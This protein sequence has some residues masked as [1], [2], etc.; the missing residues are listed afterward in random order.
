[1]KRWLNLAVAA[2]GLV[3]AAAATARAE[4]VPALAAISDT[5]ERAR[6]QAL[7]EGARKEG[8]LSWIGVQIEPGHANPILAEF[9]RYYGLDDLKGEYTYAGTGEI[10][11][12][13][14]QLLRAKRKEFDIVW[15]ASWAWYKDLLK[16]G[17]IMQYDSPHYAAYTLSDQNGMSQKGYWA[18]DAY[19]FA[20]IYNPQTMEQNGLKNFNPTSWNDFVDP[21][22]AGRICM[23]DVMVS[24]SAAPVLAGVVKAMGDEWLKKLGALKPALHIKAAQGR[25][26]VGSGEFAAT[27]L[28]SPKDAL[29]LQQRNIPTKQVFPK[30]GVVLIPFAPI[31]LSSAPHP[32]TAKLF[33]DFVRSAYGAQTVMNSGSLLFFGRPGVKSK[34]PDILPVMEEV[35]AIPFDW[36]T[37]G[38]T[39]A[40]KAFREKLR[41]A[42][43]GAK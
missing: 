11:T 19:A 13:I 42:G 15:T 23:I 35:K 32:N 17:E 7:I 1:M 39:A 2:A 24:T 14:E 28:N 16:R 4:D 6:V 36:E 9:K 27:L 37:E 40:V 8:G 26:W 10:V 33:I 25:E 31:I 22:L 21:R 12:R 20:P 30:E 41:A 38:S 5:A 43:I 18:S 3:T 29:S 34:Y